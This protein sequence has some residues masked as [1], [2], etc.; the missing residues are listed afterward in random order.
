MKLLMAGISAFLVLG[1]CASLG[2]FLP[3]SQPDQKEQLSLGIDAL[4][5]GNETAAMSLFEAV[6]SAPRLEGVTDEALFRLSLLE[7]RR[8]G[9]AM[10]IKQ[11]QRRLGRLIAEYPE[12]PWSRQAWSLMEYISE[13]DGSRSELRA[14]KLSNNALSKAN[15]ELN[16]SIH[17]LQSANQ[18]LAKENAELKL[19]IEKLKDLDI[20]LDKKNRR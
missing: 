6:C 8:Q 4:R 11:V 2:H 13:E 7:L 17:Q 19:I 10:D 16:V 12:S 3:N 14:N 5:I 20:M 18:S 9:N 1:G 15:R